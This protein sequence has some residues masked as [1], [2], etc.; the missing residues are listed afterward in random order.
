MSR[1]DRSLSSPEAGVKR[2]SVRRDCA[3]KPLPFVENGIVRVLEAL[4]LAGVDGPE[5]EAALV[6]RP[7]LGHLAGNLGQEARFPSRYGDAVDA[8]GPG[9]G[10]RVRAR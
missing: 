5:Q 10:V 7:E 6:E 1:G 8:G 2:E 4:R 9:V 3:V